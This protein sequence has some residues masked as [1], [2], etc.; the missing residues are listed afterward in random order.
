MIYIRVYENMKISFGVIILLYSSKFSSL[1]MTNDG[2]SENNQS[3]EMVAREISRRLSLTRTLR[4]S[5]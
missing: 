5:F 3:V 4:V 1:L 2:E